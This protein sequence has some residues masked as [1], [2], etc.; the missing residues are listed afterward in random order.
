MKVLMTGCRASLVPTFL[1]LFCFGLCAG[2]RNITKQGSLPKPSLRA[3]PSSVVPANSNVTLRCWTPARDVNFVLRKG[4]TVL[5]SLM[6]PGSVQGLAEFP[7]THL[8]LS[9]AGRCPL[10]PLI[11]PAGHQEPRRTQASPHDLSSLTGYLPKPSLR[12]HQSPK[13]TAGEKVTLWCQKPAHMTGFKMFAL[14]KAGTSSPVQ[15]KSSE[16]SGVEFSLQ[17]VAVGDS[18]NYSCGYYQTTA[19]FWASYRSSYL[20]IL[21]TAPPGSSSA[22]YTKGNL[23]RLGL[24]ALVMLAMGAL[25]AE[26]WCSR[27]ASPSESRSH[28]CGGER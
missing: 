17:N 9:D 14:L 8:Q 13:V 21:V 25:L 28:S 1:S 3:W 23:I 4:G 16:G 12:A 24:S 20:E 26:A 10:L 7:L 22:D 27:K 11:L 19:P 2:Q 15:Q 6:P 5:K 18:G